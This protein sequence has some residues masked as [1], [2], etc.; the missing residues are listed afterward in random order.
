M[1]FAGYDLT[2]AYKMW[3]RMDKLNSNN[4]TPEFLS[5]HPSGKTRIE[6]IKMDTF[7]TRKIVNN[8]NFNSI[9]RKLKF[10]YLLLLVYFQK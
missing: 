1:H 3:E 8:Y 7:N 2:E 4:R 5:T 9:V 6:N 10:S